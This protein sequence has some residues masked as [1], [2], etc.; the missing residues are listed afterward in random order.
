M[1]GTDKRRWRIFGAAAAL[2]L[3][4]PAVP[5]FGGQ[6]EQD[7]GGA[8][9]YEEN[10]ER[11]VGWTKIDGKW[12]A[13]DEETGVWIERPALT[14]EAAC[15]LLENYLADAGL[16]QNED[17]EVYC[18]VDYVSREGY[19]ISAGYEEKPGLFRTLNTYEVNVK[20]RTAKA[21]VGGN[22]ISL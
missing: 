15:Y 12:Y 13:L 1:K 17:E 20:N 10:G 2:A 19:T 5:A 8:W 18:R 3:I 9:Y 14:E 4:L 6:W 11:A 22:T 7:S 16:Y 21:L